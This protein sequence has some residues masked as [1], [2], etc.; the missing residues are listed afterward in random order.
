MA[1]TP[2]D[3]FSNDPVILTEHGRTTPWLRRQAVLNI[4][5][6][7]ALLAR[8]IAQF[9]EER[10]RRDYPEVFVNVINDPTQG[11]TK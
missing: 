2:E 10:I 9:G 3:E 11:D 8:M 4:R 5:R 7:P 1:V 6:D